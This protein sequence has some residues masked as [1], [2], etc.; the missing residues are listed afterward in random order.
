MHCLD[1]ERTL[2]L[3]AGIGLLEV[4]LAITKSIQ[5]FRGWTTHGQDSRN[6]FMGHPQRCH[7][8]VSNTV[9]LT[10]NSC[11]V[12]RSHQP[13]LGMRLTGSEILVNAEPS[14]GRERDRDRCSDL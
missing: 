1:T 7:F 4:V 9:G 8:S 3:L 10:S 11:F 12:V 6:P 2:W 13:A 5:E 14:A